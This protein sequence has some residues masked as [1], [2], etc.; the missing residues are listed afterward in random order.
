LID[1]FYSRAC[2]F[3][4]FMRVVYINELDS[5]AEA[6]GL[7]TKQMLANYQNIPNNIIRAIVDAN[8]TRKDFIA[9]R[10]LSRKP[11]TVGIYRLTTKSGSDNF[12]QSSVQGIMKRIKAKGV[13][14]IIFEPA[15]KDASF[16]N[17]PVIPDFDEFKKAADVIVANR[18][19]SSLDDVRDKVYTRDLYMRD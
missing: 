13:D 18:Y 8:G 16:F 10:I 12:R 9:E 19:D 2:F 6:R 14:V 17:S 1:K 5:Y 11:K 15:C 3:V 7:N 4:Q